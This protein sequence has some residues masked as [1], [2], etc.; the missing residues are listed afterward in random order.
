VGAL[1]FV[2]LQPDFNF[3]RSYIERVAIRSTLSVDPHFDGDTIE[4]NAAPGYTYR[5]ALKSVFRAWSSNIYSMD[6]IIDVPASSI[7]CHLF[8][9]FDAVNVG[10]THLINDAPPILWFQPFATPGDPFV[11]DMPP[12]PSTY[13]LEELGGF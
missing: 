8:P 2:Y 12:A 6:F 3:P 9:C 5:I 1:S 7:D 10:F 13:W 11:L 4:W